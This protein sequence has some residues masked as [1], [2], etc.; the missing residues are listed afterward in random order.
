[1]FVEI[2]CEGG[3]IAGTCSLL[4]NVIRDRKCLKVGRYSQGSVTYVT[5]CLHSITSFVPVHRQ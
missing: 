5:H 1:M 4:L 2:D 3:R